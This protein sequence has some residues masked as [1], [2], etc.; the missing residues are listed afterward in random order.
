MSMMLA[1]CSL[2]SF[3]FY[4]QERLFIPFLK[5]RKQEFTEANARPASKPASQETGHARH[6]LPR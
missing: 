2:Q 6:S 4:V 3:R 5:Y 1:H